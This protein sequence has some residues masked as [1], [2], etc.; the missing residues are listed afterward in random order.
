MS[1]AEA[2]SFEILTDATATGA[3]SSV[4]LGSDSK[5][6]Q[7]KGSTT[8]STGAATAYFNGDLF[9][10]AYIRNGGATDSDIATLQAYAKQQAGI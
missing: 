9:T 7:V 8:A 4:S 10:P 1:D 5:A 6:I 2:Q 3:S